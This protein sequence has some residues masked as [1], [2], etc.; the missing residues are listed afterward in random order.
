MGNAFSQIFPPAP[1]FTEN[2]IPDL[3]GK[4][5]IVTGASSGVGEQVATL[6]YSKNAKVYIA[7]RSKSK[8]LA[9]IDSI[10]SKYPAAEGEIL[11]LHLDLADL[12]TIKASAQEFLKDNYRL[13]V[14]INNAGCAMPPKGSKTVQGYE[15]Q[16]GVN[17]LGPFLF[18]KCLHS[19]LKDTTKVAPSCSVRVVW[20]SSN[21]A[22]LFAPK[23]GVDMDNL[24]YHIPRSQG[25]EY[26]VS[27]AGNIFHSSEFALRSK[28]EGIISV[29]L[30]PGSLK[31]ELL[32]NT[33]AWQQWLV[34]WIL[35]DS[36]YGAYTELFAAFSPEVTESRNGAYIIP[37]GRF[38]ESLRKDLVLAQRSEEEGGTGISRRFWDWSEEQVKEFS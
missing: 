14:L 20:V 35:S 11:F 38:H 30:N 26:A 19:I 4:V 27:K 6:L 22:E 33:P 34:S 9:T 15:T 31:T 2:N 25:V 3:S 28:G 10:K 1:Q 37:W 16:L 12:S 23:N 17:T 13:D 29:S 18:T 32:R 36:I 7:T 24:D 5:I 21:A 8:A